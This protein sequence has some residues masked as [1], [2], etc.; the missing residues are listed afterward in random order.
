MDVAPRSTLLIHVAR[1]KV[2]GWVDAATY[3]RTP[4]INIYYVSRVRYLNTWGKSDSESRPYSPRFYIPDALEF[5]NIEYEG[6][7][8]E[9]E[10]NLLK[11][12]T[13]PGGE[14]LVRGIILSR[15]RN[16]MR[17]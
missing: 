11:N 14:M 10:R 12:R 8:A 13:V 3:V 6:R 17:G 9:Y 7:K 15:V 4:C 5:T 1:S 2:D 16:T